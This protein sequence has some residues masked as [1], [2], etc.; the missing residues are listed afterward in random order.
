MIKVNG[1]K[2]PL[3][4]AVVALHLSNLSLPEGVEKPV[5]PLTIGWGQEDSNTK[6]EVKGKVESIYIKEKEGGRKLPDIEHR[7]IHQDGTGLR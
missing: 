4:D 6:I 5:V 3:V 7:C 2:L 1:A